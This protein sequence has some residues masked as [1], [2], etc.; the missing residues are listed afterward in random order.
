MVSEGTGEAVGLVDDAYGHIIG[1]AKA[2]SFTAASSGAITFEYHSA[3]FG[4]YGALSGTWS[5]AIAEG[6]SV[7][8][9]FGWRGKRLDITGF[10]NLGA[11]YYEPVSGQ[12]LSAD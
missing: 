10:Y 1:F 4:G 9:S 3:Q 12:F 6:V 8:R 2:A 5:P 7:W 11:R